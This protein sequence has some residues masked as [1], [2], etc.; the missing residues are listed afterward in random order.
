MSTSQGLLLTKREK[1]KEFLEFSVPSTA[2]NHLR[3]KREG[4]RHADRDTER[5]RLST[6]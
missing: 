1:E 3:M 6:L 2:L 5:E 4:E